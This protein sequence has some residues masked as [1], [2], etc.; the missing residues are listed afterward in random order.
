M[1]LEILIVWHLPEY[2]I[3]TDTHKNSFLLVLLGS[4]LRQSCW[5]TARALPNNFCL[6]Y[7]IKWAIHTCWY[8]NIIFWSHI[9][10]SLSGYL[11]SQLCFEAG[12]YLRSFTSLPTRF[13]SCSILFFLLEE[14]GRLKIEGRNLKEI[15]VIY[16]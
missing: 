2:T 14:E 3:A 11:I 6:K 12:C 16:V 15:E 1:R 10:L 8:L 13:K 7:H 9:F 5:L 4:L